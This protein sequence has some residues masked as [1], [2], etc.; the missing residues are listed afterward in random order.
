MVKCECSNCLCEIESKDRICFMC[1]VDS[2]RMPDIEKEKVRHILNQ[3]NYIF[4]I[5]I[6]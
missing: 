1:N 2:H 5:G 4:S 3:H 6:I